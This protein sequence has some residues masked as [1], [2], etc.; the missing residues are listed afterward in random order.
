VRNEVDYWHGGAQGL[1]VGDRLLTASEL[2]RRGNPYS[3]RSSPDL[4]APTNLDRVY[5]SSEREF[6]RAFGYRNELILPNGHRIRRGALYRVQPAGQIEEDPD[7]AGAGV[8]WS[9]PSAIVLEVEEPK[10]SMRSSDAV[11][12]IGKYSTWDDGRP[13]YLE[14][15]RLALTWQMEARGVTQQRLDRFIPRWTPWEDALAR[16]DKIMA[17]GHL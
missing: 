12:A 6:A 7:F 13:M 11:R 4:P 9:A 8:S 5:F 15:G 1:R 3:S 17:L 2:V 10:V 14:D 16:L